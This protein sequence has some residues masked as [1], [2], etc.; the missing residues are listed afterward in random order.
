MST[1]PRVLMGFDFGTK[2]I[3][4][5]VG[6]DLTGS[7]TPVESVAV[8][9]GKPDWSA[10]TRLISEWSP[11]ALVVGLPFRLDGAEFDLTKAAR[12]FSQQLSGRYRLPVHTL[13]ERLSSHAAERIPAGRPGKRGSI[14]ALAAQIILQTW[15]AQSPKEGHPP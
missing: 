13:D 3:G 10:I 8:T 5:A 15:L 11:Q 2:R 1:P 14:D 4:V 6:Q 7:A 9:Q 12:R